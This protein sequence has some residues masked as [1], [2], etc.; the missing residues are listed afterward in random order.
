MLRNI[1][2]LIG[3]TAA[4]L[5]LPFMMTAVQSKAEDYQCIADAWMRSEPD[6]SVENQIGLV[7]K[8][9]V[10]S[11]IDE[12]Y[13]WG[14]VEYTSSHTG[15]TLV[16]WT[17]MYLYEPVQ[18]TEAV[19]VQEYTEIP[20]DGTIFTFLT[21][22]LGFNTAQAKAVI[23]NLYFESRYNPAESVIDTNGLTSYGICQ[24]NGERF[25]RLKSFCN[26]RQLD[27]SEMDSQLAFLAY[28]LENTHSVQYDV[29]KSFPD[30]AQGCY[31]AA[32]Y[33]AENFEV[34]SSAYWTGRAESAYA[35]Y[36]NS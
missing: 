25:E 24:W 7:H 26:T 18:Y 34:C 29:M 16:G 28:E 6:S 5:A 31:D 21:E 13:G 15:S 23:T 20:A 30:T 17:A 35:Y 19:S 8:D 22:Q 9:E 11:L 2:K 32:Y 4:L 14:K 3:R 12:A 36:S 33:W 10:V 27:Y 1:K